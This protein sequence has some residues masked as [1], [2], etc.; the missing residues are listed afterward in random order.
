ML[1]TFTQALDHLEP[2]V[3]DPPPDNVSQRVAKCC[4]LVRE[5]RGGMGERLEESFLRIQ[6]SLRDTLILH[7]YEAGP[8][9]DVG[10]DHAVEQ[11]FQHDV[12][13]ELR[14]QVRLAKAAMRRIGLTMYSDADS[15]RRAV[16]H[17]FRTMYDDELQSLI[18]AYAQCAV[19]MVALAAP[20]LGVPRGRPARCPVRRFPPTPKK[21]R[22]TTH[23]ETRRT[24]GLSIAKDTTLSDP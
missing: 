19:N 10:F 8:M 23:T 6:A 4:D 18:T 22:C 13:G 21:T 14:S 15:M 2:I 12:L 24:I 9:T 17:A 11:A 7:T 3:C 1:A 5:T 20:F 16:P